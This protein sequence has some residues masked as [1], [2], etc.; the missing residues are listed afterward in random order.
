MKGGTDGHLGLAVIGHVDAGKSTTVGRL[1]LQLGACDERT[2]QKL[3]REANVAGKGSFSYAWVTDTLKA[4][5]ER[6]VTIDFSV[7]QFETEHHTFQI[8]DTPGHVDYVK[9]MITGAAQADA[10]LLVIDAR[11]G[12]FEAGAGKKGQTREHAL[13]A[14]TM[15]VRQLVI[16]VN[17]MDILNVPWD[18]NR[19][20][21]VQRILTP[22]LRRC[23]FLPENVT[24][25]PYSGWTGEG[26]TEPIPAPWYHGPT[27]AGA[28]DRLWTPQRAEHLPLRIPLQGA[29]TIAGIGTVAVGRV[30]TGVLRVGQHVKISPGDLR[31]TVTSIQIHHADIQVA[32]PGQ[33]VGFSL[34]GVSCKDLRRGM[35]ASDADA[36]PADVVDTFLAQVVIMNHPNRIVTGYTPLVDCHTSHTACRFEEIVATVNRKTGEV[37]QDHPEFVQA[38]DVCLVRMRP[39]RPLCVE[40]YAECQA[41]GRFA[42]RDLK[43]V[44]G[45]GV[46]L[47]VEKKKAVLAQPSCN[48]RRRGEGRMSAAA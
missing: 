12:A 26:L 11:E 19:F 9:N 31:G 4:E 7:R 6:G 30:E 8:V 33:N 3:A 5:R 16:G 35:V 24:F 25:V 15:G 18:R 48:K 13:L 44:V 21:E 38:G 45:V 37:I 27:I 36:S 17:K 10:A 23:G 1:L 14:Y 22:F 34:R 40:P 47:K 41:M 43:T 46:V 29:Y 20:E 42:A 28:L 2:A 32:R 39:I